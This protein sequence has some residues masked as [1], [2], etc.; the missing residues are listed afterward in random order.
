MTLNMN[1][2]IATADGVKDTI[3]QLTVW[4]ELHIPK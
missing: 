4:A 2:L 1:S 3:L